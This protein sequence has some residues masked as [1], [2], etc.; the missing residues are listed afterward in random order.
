LLFVTN[1]A[2]ILGVGTAVMAFY[3][4]HRMSPQHGTAEA[5][6]LNRRNA[7][8]VIAA[9]VVIVVVPLTSASV[10]VAH[11]TSR[12]TAVTSAVDAWL[13]GTGWALTAVTTDDNGTTTVLFQGP[14]PCPDTTGLRARLIAE[15]VPPQTVQLQFVPRKTVTLAPVG[16]P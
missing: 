7:V 10:T 16:G 14:P 13:P 2:A 11:Q 12:E 1:V 5:R 8:F 9:L 6:A 3:R 15:G 4:V